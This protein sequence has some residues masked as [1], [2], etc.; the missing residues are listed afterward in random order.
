MSNNIN[1]NNLTFSASKKWER[2]YASY[3]EGDPIFYDAGIGINVDEEVALM[4]IAKESVY[5]EVRSERTGEWRIVTV[6]AST[7]FKLNVASA[8][9]VNFRR[10]TPGSSTKVRVRSLNR[11]FSQSNNAMDD[12]IDGM[13][14]SAKSFDW[15]EDLIEVIS[16]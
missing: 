12:F 11:L 2:I 15:C 5:A 1:Q 7:Y 13:E 4:V 3:E 9:I 16:S 6:P 10:V 8:D 14:S